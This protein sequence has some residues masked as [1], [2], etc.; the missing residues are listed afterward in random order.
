MLSYLLMICLFLRSSAAAFATHHRGVG[1][2][3]SV[4]VGRGDGRKK[5]GSGERSPSSSSASLEL[6]QTSSTSRVDESSSSSPS[7]PLLRDSSTGGGHIAFRLARRSDVAGI[8]A[9]NLATLPENYN[10]N[11][12]VQHVRTWPELSLVAEHIPHG[13]KD[14]DNIMDGGGSIN[15]DNDY[16]NNDYDRSTRI[17]PLNEYWIRERR[18]KK[19]ATHANANTNYNN[20]NNNNGRP[21]KEI[22]GYILG[23]V[24]DSQ[25]DHQQ[26]KMRLLQK[27]T[28]Y[29]PSSSRIV[30][31]Y[32]YSNDETLLRYLSNDNDERN[33]N[34]HRGGGG[35][36]RFPSPRGRQQ[37]QQQQQPMSPRGVSVTGE[38]LGHVTSLAVQSHARRLGIGSSL[39][40]QLHYH[41]RECYMADSVGLHV[42][43]SNLHAVRL[44]VAEGYDVADIMPF[45]YGDG[46]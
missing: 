8:Q 6:R 40:R 39:L 11:F 24:E 28:K 43:V 45:Y 5:G 31:M 18:R 36:F 4:V 26:M 34:H 32:D 1:S 16:D 15:D 7:I 12:F 17:T 44:Y 20:N 35:R 19:E 25:H 13:Y 10:S 22:V 29:P 27:Q 21:K 23:K 33:N 2:A 14:D 37:Q 42:R 30:P 38:R 41:L 3:G 9:C 46:E